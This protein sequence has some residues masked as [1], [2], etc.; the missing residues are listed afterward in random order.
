V[1]S[2]SRE[3]SLAFRAAG[4]TDVGRRRSHNEDSVVVR[5][6]LHLFLVAD[7]AGGH[8]AGEVASLLAVT[9]MVSFFE[10]TQAETAR[11]PDCDD[12]GLLT[13]E[14][15]LARAVKKANQDIL[16][17]AA[18]HEK[19]KG[20]GTTVVAASVSPHS[21]LLHVAHVGDSRCYRLRAGYL[22]RLTQDH[23]LLVDV[24][25]LRPDI[26]DAMLA[27][28]PTNVITRAVGMDPNVRV[29]IRSY[30]LGPGD[31]YLLC[32]DGLWSASSEGDLM[33]VLAKGKTPEETVDALIALANAGGGPDNIGAL[34]IFCEQGVDAP[35]VRGP[36]TAAALPGGRT[37]RPNLGPASRHADAVP[38]IMV[39]GIEEVELAPPT[40][41]APDESAMPSPPRETAC[42]A[43][44]KLFDSVYCPFCGKRRAP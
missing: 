21:A 27:K 25:E 38:D 17:V 1:H 16:E 3:L 26:D 14:R 4:K 23:S 13:G 28:V 5:T 36:H 35:P 11:M 2:P 37:T 6:D 8:A 24:L 29:S 19:H 40:S 34:V 31:R 9:S 18:A 42:P 30:A 12:Y 32:S 43:C 39:V 7:G 33:Q 15:R 20:M 22:D 10:A 41:M 44:N